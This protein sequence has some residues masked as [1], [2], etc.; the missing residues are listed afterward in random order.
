MRDIDYFEYER[1]KAKIQNIGLTSSQYGEAIGRIL[2]S[3]EADADRAEIH[4]ARTTNVRCPACTGEL[5]PISGYFNPKMIDTKESDP[6]KYEEAW[7]CQA[8]LSCLDNSDIER[9]A[10]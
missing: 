7:E 2:K 8:C 4:E 1:R 3:L 5:K 6:R 9:L 10:A